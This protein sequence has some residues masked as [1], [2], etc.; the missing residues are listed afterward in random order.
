MLKLW[1][2]MILV[3]KKFSFFLFLCLTTFFSFFSMLLFQRPFA[4]YYDVK[5]KQGEKGRNKSTGFIQYSMDFIKIIELLVG[6]IPSDF[7]TFII[8][9]K[10]FQNEYETKEPHLETTFHILKISHK[11][12]KTCV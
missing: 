8:K 1:P 3:A 2:F 4:I 9:L 11:F 7:C 10:L 5:K 6:L 12:S